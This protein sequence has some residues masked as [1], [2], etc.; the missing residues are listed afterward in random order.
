[1]EEPCGTYSGWDPPD[2]R[3]CPRCWEL[4]PFHEPDEP[5]PEFGPLCEKH[6]HD[7]DVDPY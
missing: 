4:D 6:A 1:M 2:D 5:E 7:D 3:W